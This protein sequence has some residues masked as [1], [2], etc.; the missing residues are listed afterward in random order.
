MFLFFLGS[1]DKL[2]AD[3][4][5]LA[6]QVNI[7]IIKLYLTVYISAQNPDSLDP[8]PLDPQDFGFL[9]P[10]PQKY[11]DPKDPDPRG[12][13]STKTTKKNYSQTPDLNY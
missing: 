5:K 4:E 13:I 11:A 12:K 1:R 3:K 7:K 2:A 9:D 6:E 10:D 8:D